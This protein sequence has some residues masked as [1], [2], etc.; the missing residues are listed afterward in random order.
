[1]AQGNRPERVADLV[2]AEL[3]VLL[4]RKVRDPGVRF[5]TI[6]HVRMSQDL[7]QARVFYTAL[8]DAPARR[9]VARALDR[10]APFLRRHLGE[11]LR[12]RHVPELAFTYDETAVRQD[13]VAQVLEE[14]RTQPPAED[15][16]DGVE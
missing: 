16:Q 9:G 13:R 5:V 1:M 14:L 8:V 3:A 11:R 10:A 4:A 15:P 2:R 7:E 6:T 12:L